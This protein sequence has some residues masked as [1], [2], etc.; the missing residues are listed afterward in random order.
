MFWE[1]QVMMEP[2]TLRVL[3]VY[4]E[5]L[6]LEELPDNTANHDGVLSAHTI[7]EGTR[8]ERTD[9]GTS[10]HRGSDTTLNKRARSGAGLVIVARTILALVE[11][12]E[13]RLHG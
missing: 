9:P 8:A 13:I 5:V 4:K 12:A 7:R 6:P 11:I 2:M 1:A 3:I 10:G